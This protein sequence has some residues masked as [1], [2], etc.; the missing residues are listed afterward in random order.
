MTVS[1]TMCLPRWATRRT[2]RPS[3]G[4]QVT[5][6]AERIGFPLMPWQQQVLDVALEFDPTTGIIFDKL[7]ELGKSPLLSEEVGLANSAAFQ[8]LR[9]TQAAP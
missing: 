4:P 5:V 1:S 7:P 9:L 2:E 3:Y 6:F 8:K